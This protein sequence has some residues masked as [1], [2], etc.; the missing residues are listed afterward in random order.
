[1]N[2]VD[3]YAFF[4]AFFLLGTKHLHVLQWVGRS[5]VNYIVQFLPCPQVT[6]D[7][8]P[9]WVTPIYLKKWKSFNLKLWMVHHF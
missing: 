1:M 9:S 6:W 7:T 2:A 3:R 4:L 5:S 8:I